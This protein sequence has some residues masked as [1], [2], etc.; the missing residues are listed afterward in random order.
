MNATAAL[1]ALILQV[2][3]RPA[4]QVQFYLQFSDNHVEPRQLYSLQSF[5]SLLQA[6]LKPLQ[7]LN[8][9]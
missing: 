7:D 6:K 4:E 8:R 1:C 5:H 2:P 9:R 3:C